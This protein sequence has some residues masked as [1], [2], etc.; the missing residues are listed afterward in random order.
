MPQFLILL[1]VRQNNALSLALSSVEDH[2]Y[3][4]LSDEHH[5]SALA[6]AERCLHSCNSLYMMA[7]AIRDA[8]SARRF[9][10]FRFAQWL[11]RLC[12]S[13]GCK[14][15][16]TAYRESLIDIDDG[17]FFM[18]PSRDLMEASLVRRTTLSD[19]RLFVNIT[20]VAKLPYIIALIFNVAAISVILVIGF[21]GRKTWQVRRVELIG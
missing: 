2:G 16:V 3:L 8:T 13:P 15:K 21:L 6:E 17:K 10:K 7:F 18:L 1:R 11:F 12:Q 14:A 4:Y 19:L 9:V 20:P 5:A